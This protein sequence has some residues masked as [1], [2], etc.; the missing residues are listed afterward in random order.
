MFVDK[1]IIFV[2]LQ[3]A[4]SV[5]IKTKTADYEYSFHVEVL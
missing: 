4:I 3:E 2:T 1:K 5:Q